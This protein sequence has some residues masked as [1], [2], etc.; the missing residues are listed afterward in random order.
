M[1]S[2]DKLVKIIDKEVISVGELRKITN[3]DLV[4]SVTMTKSDTRYP[5]N[6]KYD[7]KLEN[8]ELYFVYVKR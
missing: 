3:D 8:G 4:N 6:I 5:N 2:Y 1:S 7:V